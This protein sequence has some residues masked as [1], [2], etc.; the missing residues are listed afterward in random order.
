[1]QFCYKIFLLI[2]ARTC[3]A[4]EVNYLTAYLFQECQDKC[5]IAINEVK[6]DLPSKIVV[7]FTKRARAY[8][9]SDP[10]KTE[11]CM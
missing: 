8:F 2:R 9:C 7:F 1:M 5:S 11:K 4:L 3:K 10:F 6:I